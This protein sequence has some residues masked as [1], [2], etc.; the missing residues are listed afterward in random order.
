MAG[1]AYQGYPELAGGGSVPHGHHH[2]IGFMARAYH[3]HTHGV[4]R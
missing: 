2:R 1:T 3:P 4:K